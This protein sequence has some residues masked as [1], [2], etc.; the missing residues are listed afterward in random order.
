MQTEERLEI[1]KNWSDK[2]IIKLMRKFDEGYSKE[3]VCG[4]YDI[5]IPTLEYIIY[6]YDRKFLSGE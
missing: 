4:I 6:L 3:Y 1:E 2:A 5:N